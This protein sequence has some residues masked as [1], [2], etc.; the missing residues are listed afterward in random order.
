MSA[1][2]AAALAVL[3]AAPARAEASAARQAAAESARTKAV[4]D[5]ARCHPREYEAWKDGPH[6]HTRSSFDAHW[7]KVAD[8]A[9]DIPPDMRAFLKTVDPRLSCLPCHAPLSTDY[10]RSLPVDWDG[11]QKIYERPLALKADDPV[12]TSGVDCVTCHVDG[13]GRVIA[14]ADYVR[15]PGLKPPPGFCDPVA[16][17]TFSHPNNCLPCHGDSVRAVAAR[18]DADHPEKSDALR[19][20]TCHWEKDAGGRRTHWEIWRLSS[21]GGDPMNKAA[22]DALSLTVRRGAKGRELLV[23][24]TL[25]FLPHP[26]VANS[27]K[28]YAF[29]FEFLDKTGAVV[30][31]TKFGLAKF[32]QPS[33]LA[34][35]LTYFT[36][37]GEEL[38]APRPG[39]RFTRALPLPDGVPD[40][41]VVRLTVTKRK[42]YYGPDSAQRTL[43][44]RETPY[45]L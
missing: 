2:L 12:L 40:A 39:E 1:C 33:D 28:W 26:M 5:C 16:S 17:K 36:K 38:Y 45:S 24:W 27:Y 7:K 18:F 23:D 29:R 20:E 3:C 21:H 35:A 8:P 11:R 4:L 43:Y 9:S 32:A 30:H 15:T 44:V 41:G 13:R 10:T 14:R 31:A 25:D 19:C 34:T 37:T 22:L 6:S 42:P